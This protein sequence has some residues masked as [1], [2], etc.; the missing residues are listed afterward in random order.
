MD[1]QATETFDPDI[2]AFFQE[3]SK[4]LDECHDRHE[5]LVKISRDITIESKVS[6]VYQSVCCILLYSPW[7]RF[8]VF[9]E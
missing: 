6:E 9:R 5:R 1:S 3:C 2:Q 4:K 8:T 7:A